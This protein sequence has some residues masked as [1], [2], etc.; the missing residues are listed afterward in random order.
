[1]VRFDFNRKSVF[2][3]YPRCDLTKLQ[4]QVAI[5][6]KFSVKSFCISVE[7]HQDGT[8][9]VH[10][11]FVFTHK[12]HTVDPRAFDIAGHHPNIAG[13]I[14]SAKRT[15]TYI[16]KHGDYVQSDDL[17]EGETDWGTIL[18]EADSEESFINA[19]KQRYPRDYVLNL[20]KIEYTASRVF[21][22]EREVYVSPYDPESWRIPEAL[23][24]WN[25]DR[26][27]AGDGRPKSLVLVG[28]TR[29]GKTEWARSLGRHSYF[30]CLF[31][32]DEHDAEA[33]YAIFDDCNWKF[34]PSKKGWFGAQKEFICTDKYRHKR[35][36]KWGKPS[37]FS[38]N[39]DGYDEMVL[40]PEWQWIQGNCVIFRV[41]DK[42]YT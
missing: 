42:L 6:E 9:H 37:I 35:K 26:I 30:N 32:L 21:G 3:T 31:S 11:Y 23:S 10:A 17:E 34:L 19:V 24:Q 22:G 1:M 38:C 33:E 28:D 14:R 2:L 8:P 4:V 25:D 15:L 20:S 7:A 27:N 40:S 13:A 36:I 41:Q 29:L 39:K 18:T 5:E 12:T 16:R